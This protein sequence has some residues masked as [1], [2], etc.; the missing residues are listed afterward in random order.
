M[1][2]RNYVQTTELDNNLC[3]LVALLFKPAWQDWSHSSHNTDGT[4]RQLKD[5]HRIAQELFRLLEAVKWDLSF[6]SVE[7]QAKLIWTE[8]LLLLAFKVLV[9]N[10]KH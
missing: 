8:L 7:Y 3:Q 1:T 10:G 6:I 5:K 4:P 2:G 9:M